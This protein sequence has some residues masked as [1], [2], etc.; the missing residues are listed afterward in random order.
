L[1][2]SLLKQLAARICGEKNFS[3]LEPEEKLEIGFA[4][5]NVFTK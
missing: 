2:T 4:S 5:S 3:L 1:L